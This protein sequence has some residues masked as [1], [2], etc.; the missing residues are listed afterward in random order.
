MKE[1][2]ASIFSVRVLQKTMKPYILVFDRQIP[3]YGIF[4]YLGIIVAVTVALLICRRKRVEW[5]DV[6]YSGVYAM[7]GGILGAKLLFLAVS[8]PQI[9]AEQIPLVAVLK[10]GFVFYGGLLGGLL[11][12]FIYVKQ[13]HMHMG[14]LLEIYATVLPLGHAFGRVGCFFAG[15]CYGIPY[16][17]ALS[18][19]YRYSIGNTPIDVPL[20]PIQL[21]ESVGLLL[22][23]LVLLTVYWRGKERCGTVV[24]LY[25]TVYPILRFVLDFFRGDVERGALGLFS[26]SQWVSFGI[27]SATL[28]FLLLKK[29]KNK[30]A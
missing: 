22:I 4:F 14:E 27:L 9:I 6:A 16:D 18:H 26:T 3:V 30:I 11:G 5:Y 13:F 8:F 25:L 19:T 29:R 2:R 21:I 1:R 12:L 17:G 15:C 28:L 23:F 10:G 20:L 24:I 7:I